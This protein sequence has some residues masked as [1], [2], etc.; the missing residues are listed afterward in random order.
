MK[1]LLLYALPFLAMAC[2]QE[3]LENVADSKYDSSQELQGVVMTIPDFNWEGTT[4]TSL[5]EAEHGMTFAWAEGDKV[6][7]YASNSMASFNI[8]TIGSDAKSASFDGGGFSL[9]AGETYYSFSPYNGDGTDKTVVPVSFTGQIQSG[10]ADASHLGTYDFMTSKATAY[11]TNEALFKFTHLGAIMRIKLSV[12]AGK[13]YES[14]KVKGL[15]DDESFITAGTVDLTAETPVITTTETSSEITLGLEDCTASEDGIL[16]LYTMVAPM[17]LSGSRLVFTVTDTEGNE[18]SDLIEGKNMLAGKAYGYEDVPVTGIELVSYPG[19]RIIGTNGYGFVDD[20][21]YEGSLFFTFNVLPSNAS[22]RRVIIT[23]SDNTIADAGLYL[24]NDEDPFDLQDEECWLGYIDLTG[25]DGDITIT[26]TTEDG[27]YS[28]S[29]SFNCI[30]GVQPESVWLANFSHIMKVGTSTE[31]FF[32]N[33]L[34]TTAEDYRNY[35]FIYTSSN[36]SV[37]TIDDYNQINAVGVGT[38]KVIGIM[39]DVLTGEEWRDEEEIQ[40]LSEEDYEAEF[41]E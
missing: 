31:D 30:Y 16:T 24:P 11:A 27:G 1:K 28:T 38:A 19:S 23:S 3:G 12:P 14:L 15:Y 36:T 7:V 39:R 21:Y 22:N 13:N 37:I 17:N 8:G 5:S 34:P 41:G 6:G 32:L 29:F 20:S 33:Y 10:N 26:I 4:R 9:T 25:G 40:V 2:S 18:Y 35:D